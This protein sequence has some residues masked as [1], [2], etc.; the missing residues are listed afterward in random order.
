MN[1]ADK[2]VSFITQH[3]NPEKALDLFRHVIGERGEEF[4]QSVIVH[5]ANDAGMTAQGA[6]FKSILGKPAF[7]EVNAA[8]YARNA[9]VAMNMIP[10]A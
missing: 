5:L 10:A 3:L 8:P 7:N 6:Q 9:E 4:R 1:I 2:I